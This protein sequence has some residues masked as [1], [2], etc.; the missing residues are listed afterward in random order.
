MG[1]NTAVLYKE[2]FMLIEN[3][4]MLVPVKLRWNYKSLTLV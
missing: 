1:K 2:Q 3:K 4:S